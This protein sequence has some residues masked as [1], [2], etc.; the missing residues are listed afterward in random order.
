[1]I[2][3]YL[4]CTFAVLFLGMSS[5]LY[6]QGYISINQNGTASTNPAILDLSDASNANLGFLMPNV[7]LAS[8]SDVTT[9]PGPVAGTIVWNTNAS[10]PLGVG[11]YY[12]SGTAWLYI[13]NSGTGSG[14]SG[15]GT[16]NYLARW[17]GTSTLNTGVSQDNGTGVS[18]SSTA[19]TP[20]NI[21]DV[22]GSAAFGTYAGSAGP[23]NGLVISGTT[24][25][26][27]NSPNTSA[28][29]DITSSTQGLLPPRM[30]GTQVAAISTPATGLMVLN[31]TT[32]CVE[33][34][35]GTAW[36]NVTCPCT[37]LTAMPGTITGPGTF[38]ASS[39]GN[40]YSVASITGALYYNWT[41]PAGATITAGNG[42]TSI[43]VTF[44]STTGDITVTASNSC[45]T[46]AASSFTA[47]L[48]SIPATPGTITGAATP[49]SSTTGNVYSI[50][51]VAGATSYNWTV[52]AGATIT[53]N[54]GTSITVT[55]GTTSGNITVTATNICGTSAPSSTTITLN[56]IPAA[57]GT[58]TGSS[59]PC[60]SSTGNVYSIASVAGATTYNWTVPAG[61]SIT[62]GTGTTSITVTMGTTP[63]TISVTAGNA[64]GTSAASTL[65]LTLNA[66]PSTPGAITGTSSYCNQYGTNNHI[67]SI[68]AV[69]NATSYT[70]TVPAAV[71][72]SF[73][74]QGTTSINVTLA[75]SYGTG[76]ITVVANNVC[77]S[78]AAASLAVTNNGTPPAPAT[79]SGNT[80]PAISTANTYTVAAIANATSYTWSTSNT[81]ATVTASTANSATIT[82]ASTAG[83]YNVCCSASNTC[84][85]S[86][87]TCLSLTS[88]A[89]S[90]S[91]NIDA[92]NEIAASST[93]TMTLATTTPNEMIII[94]VAG[95]CT[96]ASG[97]VKVDGNNATFIFS[98]YPTDAGTLIYGYVAATA[99]THTILISTWSETTTYSIAEAASFK[100]FCSLPTVAGNVSH[101]SATGTNS[102]ETASLTPPTA[103]SYLFGIY[104]QFTDNST[105]GAMTWTNLTALNLYHV[106]GG[107]GWD[108]GFAGSQE[109][110][111]AAVSVTAR[112]SRNAG[113]GASLDL[114]DIHP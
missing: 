39:T 79:P 32:G 81:Y 101:A 72:S 11:F 78:S 109:A 31:T 50:A 16:I 7:N 114:V 86:A 61:A 110:T 54:T 76:N 2:K 36:Q 112:D 19:L 98:T 88:S 40:V 45:G 90:A 37:G 70:W 60:S 21:L 87:S 46:S 12:Y 43:T 113:Y 22:K 5:L 30:T 71:G 18:V 64:C 58:I 97:V 82:C 99:G 77:G 29:L 20:A 51:A 4:K 108:F 63:G 93:N 75:S 84:G 56:N 24:G 96:S 69:A 53:A 38:C 15:S 59:S 6:S 17:T 105:V 14:P 35:N 73:T 80:T 10:L 68:A 57:P 28:A 33:Y 103:H 91:I 25:I 48:T 106:S 55:F 62:A 27:T 1:M 65:L 34:Y 107:F 42:T 66:V 47:T 94:T 9:I 26:G 95:C 13:Y 3:F 52:P 74:G 92:Q 100:G 23:A 8:T 44:G 104:N 49:C 102:S 89:C 67:Y 85:T 83:S 111:T 41:V